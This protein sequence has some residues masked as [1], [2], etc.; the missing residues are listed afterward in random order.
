[1]TRVGEVDN[2][3]ATVPVEVVT[4]VPPLAT[5][6]VVPVHTPVVIVPMETKEDKVVTALLTKV[7]VVGRVTLV[8]P[9]EVKVML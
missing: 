2:T 8:V 1:M 4:P 9:V 5:A 6:I 7:P 3:V